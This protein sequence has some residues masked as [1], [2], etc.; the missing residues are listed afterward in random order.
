MS[1]T[2]IQ[3]KCMSCSGTGKTNTHDGNPTGDCVSCSGSG[4][5]VSG[6]LSSD[7]VDLIQD[8]KDKVDDIFEKV[9][10]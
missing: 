10:E 6:Y 9:N 1:N 5:L 8:I 4:M 7:L 2:E 3:S